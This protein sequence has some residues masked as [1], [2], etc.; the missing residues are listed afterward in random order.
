MLSAAFPDNIFQPAY[1]LIGTISSE[2]LRAP[3]K[4]SRIVPCLDSISCS[5]V[6]LTIIDI[7]NICI[8]I[9]L[10]NKKL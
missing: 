8:G 10:R 5:L 1:Q 6:Q 9:S 7:L 3:T 4:C 2:V